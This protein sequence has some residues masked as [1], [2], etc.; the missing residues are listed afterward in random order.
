MANKTFEWPDYACDKCGL[1]KQWLVGRA[2]NSGGHIVCVFFC[3]H[4]GHRT[5]HFVD[6]KSVTDAGEYIAD[7]KTEW[8]LKECSVCHEL[9]AENHHWA[10]FALFGEE[11]E[12][13]PQS[14]LCPKCHAR[15]HRIVTPNAKCSD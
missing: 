1:E 8:E 13:W 4:C 15:W 2:K 5:T 14:Y 10:P 9:G 3:G 7:I 12:L 6:C 11:S